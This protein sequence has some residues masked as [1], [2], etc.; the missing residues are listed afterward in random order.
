MQML[1]QKDEMVSQHHGLQCLLAFCLN[2][3][4]PEQTCGESEAAG[5]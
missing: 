3:L 2:T 5:H 1:T 4:A